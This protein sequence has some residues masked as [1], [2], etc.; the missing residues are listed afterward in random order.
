MDE[1]KKTGMVPVTKYVAFNDVDDLLGFELPPYLADV[2]LQGQHINVSVSNP[3][4]RFPWLFKSPSDAHTQQDRNPAV[5]KAIVE[6]INL[7]KNQ[8]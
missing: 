8:K 1:K 4:V 5:I 3:G 7:P 6:G 2:G